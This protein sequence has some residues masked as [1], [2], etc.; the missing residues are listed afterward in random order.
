MLRSCL[1]GLVALMLLAGNVWAQ[2]IRQGK[3]KKVDHARG[4]ITI[5]AGGKDLEF[6]VGDR[7]RV[8]DE[9]FQPVK[10][11][12]RDKRFK[13]G[14]VVLF[15]PVNNEPGTVLQGLKLGGRP[16]QAH[17]MVDGDGGRKGEHDVMMLRHGAHCGLAQ[18]Y[19]AD[20]D[21]FET[22]DDL[23]RKTS[24]STARGR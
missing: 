11:R 20:E 5:T 3:I 1:C 9:Q 7:T 10:D 17:P 13:P 4:T 12:L 8:M 23:D 22:L 18:T 6:K 16:P 14:A 24:T 21:I 2:R 15:K 19:F